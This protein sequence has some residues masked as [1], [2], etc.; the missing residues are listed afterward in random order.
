MHWECPR[1]DPI[2]LEE[3]GVARP[4]TSEWPPCLVNAGILPEHPDFQALEG[5][6]PAILQ[7]L[8]TAAPVPLTGQEDELWRDGRVI[9]HTDGGDL[10]PSGDERLHRGG[11]SG[12][13]G[14]QH[15]RNNEWVLEGPAQSINRA[16]AAAVLRV[17]RGEPRPVE[18]RPDSEV[19]EMG[20]RAL[21]EGCPPD[22]NAA[23][24]DLWEQIAEDLAA[25]ADGHV[26]VRR[27]SSRL[28]AE[29]AAKST[30]A[31]KKTLR[32]IG[33]PH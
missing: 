8:A 7:P 31:M 17:L 23:N 22:P 13:W 11:S 3:L 24:Y 26:E 2:R 4:D 30:G 28:T 20:L 21:L 12:F 1:S 9:V 27:V 14:P 10:F 29:Q 15:P 6:L 32:S 5:L 33:G 25:R 19:T 16:E 18:V